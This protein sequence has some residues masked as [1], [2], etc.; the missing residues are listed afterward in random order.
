M[1][2]W[3]GMRTPTVFFL[4]WRSWRGTSLVPG[5]MKVYGLGVAAFTARKT[6]LSMC[7][8]CPS[9]AKSLH[10]RVKWCRSSR[11]R[12]ALMRPMPSRLPMRVPSA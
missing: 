12:I 4:G 10:M 3:S 7:T 5:R 8:S 11:S 6:S 1:A 2:T 9:W